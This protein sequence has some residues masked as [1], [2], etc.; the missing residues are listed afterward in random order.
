M[1]EKRATKHPAQIW[2]LNRL[3]L[4]VVMVVLEF[5]ACLRLGLKVLGAKV[6]ATPSAESLSFGELAESMP[7]VGY[8]WS[9]GGQNYT[10][11]TSPR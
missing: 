6:N 2:M 1:G 5:K 3:V 9:K 8:P 10:S 11:V 7:G 4:R